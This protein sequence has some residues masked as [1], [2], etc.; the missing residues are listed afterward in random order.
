MPGQRRVSMSQENARK[1]EVIVEFDRLRKFA[2]CLFV[3]TGKMRPHS[4]AGLDGERKRVELQRSLKLSDRLVEPSHR[5]EI[6]D[7]VPVVGGRVA[8]V[9]ID[10]S[11][12]V[13][14]GSLPGPVVDRLKT[15]ATG[16]GVG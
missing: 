4:K 16:E 14:L 13:T 5:H 12:E 7:G 6:V 3:L 11:F 1:H 8:G 15:C 2:A 10:R 9:E